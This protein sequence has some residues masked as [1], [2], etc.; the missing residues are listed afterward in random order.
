[1]DIK[2]RRPLTAPAMMLG[3]QSNQLS[4]AIP[5]TLHTDSFGVGARD[6]DLIDDT[7]KDSNSS[8]IIGTWR[9]ANL[10]SGCG[11]IEMD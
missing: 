11:R 10:V 7:P 2:G 9:S 5:S 4:M 8:E 3:P 6:V 1:M